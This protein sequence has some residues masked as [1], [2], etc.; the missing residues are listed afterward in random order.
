MKTCCHTG[1]YLNYPLKEVLNRLWDLGYDG[2]E[3]SATSECGTYSPFL[4][5]KE[6]I[7]QVAQKAEELDLQI[8]S[9]DC[10]LMPTFGRNIVSPFENIRKTTI[11][12]IKSAIVVAKELKAKFVVINAGMAMY[13][14]DKKRAWNWATEGLKE[15]TR[16]AEKCNI[17]LAL[18]HLT[19][20]EGN[21][22][23][24]LD[25]SLSMLKQINSENLVALLDTGHVN[26]NGE[27]ITD[28]V[29]KLAERLGHI[30]INDNDGRAD[31]HLGPGSGTINFDPLFKALNRV[32]YE[33]YLSIEP[34]FAF[35][36][37]PDST[38][39]QG[40]KFFRK[41]FGSNIRNRKLLQSEEVT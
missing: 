28:Y 8:V 9:Y 33:G 1:F 3:I 14:I 11:E 4:L 21:V 39:S 41:H 5:N 22:V 6:R 2:V 32:S 26:V 17:H 18:E 36:A 38:A 25:D 13:D 19:L 7:Q 27:S 37:D 35:S 40:I 34:S 10:E 20:L 24:T 31:D 12:Y 15:C 16:Y 23:V 29:L 30:H